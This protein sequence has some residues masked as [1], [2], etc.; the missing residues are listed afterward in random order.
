MVKDRR[1]SKNSL[2]KNYPH[3][4]KTL[5]R[6]IPLKFKRSK[7]YSIL[8]GMVPSGVLALLSGDVQRH[9]RN[10]LLDSVVKG[11]DILPTLMT[12]ELTNH[13][14][15][16]CTFCTQP[17]IMKRPKNFMSEAVLI[18]C[19]EMVKKYNI[20]E[21]ML[22]GMGEPFM[23]K[24]IVD[25]ITVLTGSGVFVSVT[26]NGSILHVQKPSDIVESGL[27]KLLISMDALDSEWLQESKPGI[28]KSVTAIEQDIK[29]IY[30]YKIRHKFAKPLMIMKYQILENSNYL[31]DKEE[32]KRLIR[33]KVGVLCDKVD[34]RQ[35][36]DWLGNAAEGVGNNSKPRATMMNICNQLVRTV[37]VSWNGDVGLCC[38]DYD[39]KVKLGN[40]LENDLPCIYNSSPMMEARKMY[41]EGEAA[42]HFMCTGCYS[43]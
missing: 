17:N 28:K 32:E 30:D 24:K 18:R 10:M 1:H 42:A 34:L 37:E 2:I 25:L 31:S 6:G 14:N 39:N 26:T 27:D 22:A 38:M 33:S 20:S 16:G 35:Q 15:A 21:V 29:E 13:C 9:R 11:I 8:K 7:Y 3:N 41:V 40:I 4:M 23:Y 12:L 43:P 19:V 36:H 5:E